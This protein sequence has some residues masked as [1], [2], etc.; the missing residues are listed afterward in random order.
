MVGTYPREKIAIADFMKHGLDTQ[1]GHYVRTQNAATAARMANL[2]YK[3]VSGAV[4]T[5]DDHATQVFSTYFIFLFL[6][7]L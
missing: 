7:S 1:E 6:F 3:T 4:T 2:V 5:P